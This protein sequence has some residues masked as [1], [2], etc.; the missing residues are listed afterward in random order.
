MR[1]H[2]LLLLGG[3]LGAA[4]AAVAGGQS[5]FDAK[6]WSLRQE[7][8]LPEGARG[9]VAVRPELDTW[10]D[11]RLDLNDVRIGTLEGDEIPYHRLEPPRGVAPRRDTPWMEVE[12]EKG[13]YVA[14]LG[15]EPFLHDRVVVKPSRA[16]KLAAVVRLSGRAQTGDAWVEILPS[17]LLFRESMACQDL[18]LEYP[19]SDVRYLRLVV[20][21]VEDWPV[22]RPQRAYAYAHR[23][24][25]PFTFTLPLSLEPVAEGEFPQVREPL[26]VG[27]FPSRHIP[28]AQVRLRLP[29]PGGPLKVQFGEFL[30]G[31]TEGSFFQPEGNGFLWR[32]KIGGMD[33]RSAALSSDTLRGDRLFVRLLDGDRDLFSRIREAEVI[34]RSPL[35]VFK[36]TPGEK[37]ALYFHRGDAGAPDY[38]DLEELPEALD[39]ASLPRAALGPTMDNPLY[40][41]MEPTYFSRHPRLL[42]GGFLAALVV[43]LLVT[44][45]NVFGEKR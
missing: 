37:Y 14:D 2:R 3:V 16:G 20:E 42:W 26:L 6:R 34:C 28:V 12:G 1:K 5:S 19:A 21:P 29:E 32:R 27:N 11:G 17:T 7:I 23:E 39:P 31:G 15:A 43:L 45:A 35:F 36:A 10:H 9:W 18:V 38:P 13:V 8:R 30:R 44:L 24:F 41:K 40:E 25:D 4:V 33:I 22:I